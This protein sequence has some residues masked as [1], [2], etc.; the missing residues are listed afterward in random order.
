MRH[1][2][3][4][5]TTAFVLAVSCPPA[6]SADQQARETAA[7]DKDTQSAD[8]KSAEL[9]VDEQNGAVRILIDGRPIVIIDKDGLHVRE[10]INYGGTLTDYGGVGFDQHDGESGH[11]Q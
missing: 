5:F 10:S 7:P 6:F 9:V 1:F 11:E 2:I 4:I 3:V 8:V